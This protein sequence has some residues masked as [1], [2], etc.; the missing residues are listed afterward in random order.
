MPAACGSVCYFVN[1]VS[2]P[3]SYANTFVWLCSLPFMSGNR[4][5]FYFELSKSLLFVYCC[6]FRTALK[7]I[8]AKQDVTSRVDNSPKT[9]LESWLT[10][11]DV[12][13]KDVL[14]MV[15]DMLLAG[16]DTVSYFK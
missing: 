9:L 11:S 16:I 12:D 2:L 4:H 13:S 15:C 6:F 5:A 8:T 3:R 1:I 10:S 7:Y 14:A